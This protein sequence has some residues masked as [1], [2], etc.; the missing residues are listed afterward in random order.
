MA[1]EQT[2]GDP[3][4]ARSDIYAVGVVLFEM[5]S[6]TRPFRS[7]QMAELMRM[8]REAPPPTLRSI[9]PDAGFS[10]AME[11]VVAR[12]LAKARD[13]RFSS[14]AEFA[15]ALDATPEAAAPRKDARDAASVDA[16]VAGRRAAQAAPA[17]IAAREPTTRRSA[18]WLPW[19]AAGAVALAGILGVGAW[20]ATRATTAP[21]ATVAAAPV[22]APEEHPAL[23]THSETPAHDE[24]AAPPP[25]SRAPVPGLAHAQALV[26]AGHGA[27]A[28]EELRKLRVK[29]P[30]NPDVAYW[31]GNVYFDR[32]WWSDGFDAYRVAVREPAYRQD[33]TLITNVLKS[34]ISESHG[35]TGARFIEREIG[36]AAIPYV[37][38]ATR[39]NSLSVR[40][41]A[42]HVLANLNRGR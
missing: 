28:L 23:P 11:A 24:V 15:A 40:G 34:F 9:A 8:Q 39:S 25:V 21:A 27:A 4:D 12:A 22:P 13:A 31:M 3:V 1:P 5:L 17:S 2:C 18:R 32:M 42:A 38:Q 33:P 20:L 16:T 30:D 37:E 35:G 29:Y 26:R 10:V 36:A 6:G 41:R 7:E 14:A 19:A